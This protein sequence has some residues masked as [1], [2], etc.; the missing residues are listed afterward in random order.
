[1]WCGRYYTHARQQPPARTERLPEGL[2]P[3]LRLAQRVARLVQL[4]VQPVGPLDLLEA[5]LLRA[6][7][8]VARLLELLVVHRVLERAP[9]LLVWI[10]WWLLD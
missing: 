8:L 5:G 2:E 6:R 3:L 9:V 10:G 1:M 7:Q 4:P